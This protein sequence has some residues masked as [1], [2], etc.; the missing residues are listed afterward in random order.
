MMGKQEG[1]T[2]IGEPVFP[3]Y[4]PIVKEDVKSSKTTW[5]KKK[6]GI[7]NGRTTET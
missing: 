7:N 2:I 3:F 1:F 4:G 6:G 5:A